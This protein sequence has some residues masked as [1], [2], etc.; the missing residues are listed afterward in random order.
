MIVGIIVG[1]IVL[2]LL[3]LFFIALYIFYRFTFYSPLK[4]QLDDYNIMGSPQF[5]NYRE[6]IIKM[7]DEMRER[8]Y[9]DVWTESYDKLKLHARVFTNKN[10]KKIAILFHGY[11]GTGNRDFCG[12]AKEAL[13]LGYTVVL[14]DQRAHGLSEGHSIT[15]GVRE[16]KDALTWINFVYEK[17]GQDIELVLIGISMGGAIVLNVADKV[18]KNVKII[19]DC[20]FSSPKSILSNSIKAMKLSVKIFYPLVN[21]ASILFGHTNMNKMS[22]YDTVKNAQGKIL[23][24][25]GDADTVVPYTNSQDLANT[26]PDKIQY[27]LFHGADHGIS[28]MVDEDRYRAI[29]TKFLNE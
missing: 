29:I 9:E 15:F 28:Y 7:I 18:A 22:N 8:A 2:F 26:Y 14:I 27:E 21:L 25:H 1:S 12:G 17:Y 23:I 4:D 24:I 5:N 19:A 3:I 16:S 20:P 11:R 10:P 6:K 13:A